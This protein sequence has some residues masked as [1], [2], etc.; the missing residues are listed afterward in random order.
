[1]MKLQITYDRR[2]TSSLRKAKR[3]IAVEFGDR[4]AA[5]RLEDNIRKGINKRM[6]MHSLNIVPTVYAKTKNGVSYYR[7]LV[8][9]YMVFYYIEND[10]MV[11]ARLLHS[12]QG[13][14]RHL[15]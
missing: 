15:L 4:I 3:Y 7:I 14:R 13:I 1:M 9:R 5:K 10:I 11:I 6:S 8:G 12:S 2:F